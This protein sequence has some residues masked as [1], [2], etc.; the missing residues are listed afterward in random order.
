MTTT[1][2]A[3]WIQTIDG[4]AFNLLAPDPSHIS[5]ATISVVLSRICRFGGHCRQFYSVAEHSARVCDLV[6]LATPGQHALHFAALLHDA[7][8]AFSGF[9][10]VC[11]PAKK[12]APV[13]DQIHAGINK[14]IAERFEFPVELFDHEQIHHADNVMLATEL[15]DLMRTPPVPWDWLPSPITSRVIPQTMHDA[16]YLFERIARQICF[17]LKGSGD[18]T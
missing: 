8:E 11:R 6:A 12:L 5:I 15:R 2:Q 13:I 18:T 10:D 16:A 3:P 17:S 1:T 9:G 4:H 7:H 14:A